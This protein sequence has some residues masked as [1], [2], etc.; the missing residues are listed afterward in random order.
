MHG[1][2]AAALILNLAVVHGE[3]V[4]LLHLAIV[5]LAL[6][7]NR[8]VV[9]AHLGVDGNGAIEILDAAV[10]EVDGVEGGRIG[11]EGA[12]AMSCWR[13]AIRVRTIP[14]SS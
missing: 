3:G 6:L 13:V 1:V 4:G 14:A 5:V 10:D 7:L 11:G 9:A 2:Q 8:H 12:S